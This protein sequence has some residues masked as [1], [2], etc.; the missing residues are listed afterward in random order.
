MNYRIRLAASDDSK[1]VAAL[2]EELGYRTDERFI[3]DQL[4]RLASQL[5][6]SFAP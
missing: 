4:A 3:R 1:Q 5:L 6:L 2:I